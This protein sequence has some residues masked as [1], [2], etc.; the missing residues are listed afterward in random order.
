MNWF[1]LGAILGL[2]AAA[3]FLALRRQSPALVWVSGLLVNA[4][5]TLAWCGSPSGHLA[6]LLSVQAACLGVS[7]VIWTLLAAVLHHGVPH[8]RLA[9]RPLVLAHV[10][11]QGG[12][13][14]TGLVALGGLVRGLLDWEPLA[15]HAE[16][17]LAV[18]AIGMALVASLWD[19]T[20][21][22]SLAGLYVCGLTAVGLAQVQRGFSP[23]RFFVWGSVCD[24]AGFVLVTALLGWVLTRIGSRARKFGDAHRWSAVWFHCLQALLTL[25][26]AA[27][28]VSITADVS[29]D[30]MGAGVALFGLSGRLVACPAAL[31]L[32]GAA[33]LMAWQSPGRW[34]VGWQYAALGLGMLFT[35]S[36]GWA[37]MDAATGSP[38]LHRTVNLLISASMM[39]LMTGFGLGRVLPGGSDWIQRGRRAMPAFGTLALLLAA[40]LIACRL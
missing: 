10:A 13:V 4:A 19:P 24:L 36:I 23:G 38:W 15:L 6:S 1:Y 27:L 34:R 37:T 18:I 30:G 39:T 28:A 33:I 35:T 5:G 2:S 25:L 31:M 12:V 32:L 3:G 29:F 21:K 20:A 9:R 26:V 22:F 7:S 16:D 11:V 14:L 17:W 8:C 40:V